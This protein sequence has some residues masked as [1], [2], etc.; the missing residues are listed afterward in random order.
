MLS[1][2]IHCFCLDIHHGRFYIRY[3]KAH[4]IGFA[5]QAIPA[6]TS[7]SPIAA[8]ATTTITTQDIIDLKR[9]EQAHIVAGE[10]IAFLSHK[11]DGRGS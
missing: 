6:S 1:S 5:I 10:L 4:L 8:A 7:P 2:L 11:W 9:E 3:V